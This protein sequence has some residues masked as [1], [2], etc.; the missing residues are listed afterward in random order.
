M[1]TGP[2]QVGKSLGGAHGDVSFLSSLVYTSY[3]GLSYINVRETAV[4]CRAWVHLNSGQAADGVHGVEHTGE[5][6]NRAG[7][8]ASLA[9]AV[10]QGHEGV[11][12]DDMHGVQPRLRRCQQ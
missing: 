3:K 2:P 6:L 7:T 11:K 4:E 1:L 5:V 9:A 12:S 8:V 10:D